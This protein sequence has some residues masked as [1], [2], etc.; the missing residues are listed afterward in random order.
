MV[1]KKV[2][3]PIYPFI[4]EQ[5]KNK[6]GITEGFCVD[7]GSGPGSFAIAMALITNLKSFHLIFNPK[8]QF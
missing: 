1:A 6:F 3:A 8:W 4:A 7:I 5:I 2:F